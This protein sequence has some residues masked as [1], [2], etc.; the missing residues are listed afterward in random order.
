MPDLTFHIESVEPTS[1]AAVPQLTF[2]LRIRDASTPPADVQSLLLNTQIRIEPTRRSYQGIDRP[3]LRDL[4]GEPAR[5]SSTMRSLLW[6]HVTTVVPGFVGETIVE[7]I[8]PCTFD[9]NVA[10]TK[11]IAALD[12]GEIPLCFLYSGTMFYQSERG[13]QIGQISWESE[14]TFRLPV[15]TWQELRRRHEP[16]HVWLSIPREQFEQLH[17]FK[18]RC[19]LPTWEQALERL[20]TE[21]TSSSTS[22]T[23][24]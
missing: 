19:A 13:L 18:T 16:H 9:F 5:W 8:V 10:A 6:T 7:L 3:G 24:P 14:S 4:F 15:E 1:Y 22:G 23:S 2:K 12:D 17:E 21:Q 11:Y 20:L